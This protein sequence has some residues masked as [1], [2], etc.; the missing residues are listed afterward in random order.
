LA[1][2]S[3]APCPGRNIESTGAGSRC[4]FA[5][6]RTFGRLFLFV[7]AGYLAISSFVLVM[8]WEQGPQRAIEARRAAPFT[9]RQDA[10]MVES[11][12]AL[13]L[14]PS[15][16]EG[17]RNWPGF[18]RVSPCAI[19]EWEGEWGTARSAFCGTREHLHSEFRL[20][21]LHE[22]SP[23][24]AFDFARDANGFRVPEIRMTQAALGLSLLASGH[25]PFRQ[26]FRARRIPPSHGSPGRWRHR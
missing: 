9:M 3:K 4:A 14:D 1:G 23:G 15:M 17:K 21:D 7:G 22:L 12:V 6:G 26:V 2:A 10:R 8:A 24:V 13:E 18:A 25:E 16:L 11:W 5:I 20:H 19:V